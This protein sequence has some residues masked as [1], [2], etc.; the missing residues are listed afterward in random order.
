MNFSGII[1]T[2]IIMLVLGLF[3]GLFLGVAAIVFKVKVNEKEEAV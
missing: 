2:L 1:T 3:V